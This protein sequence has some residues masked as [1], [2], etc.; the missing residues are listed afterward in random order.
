MPFGSQIKWRPPVLSSLIRWKNC[1]TVQGSESLWKDHSWS[2][3]AE[4]EASP[5]SRK[6][7][8]CGWKWYAQEACHLSITLLGLLRCWGVENFKWIKKRHDFVSYSYNAANIWARNALQKRNN[9]RWGLASLLS[10]GAWSRSWKRGMRVSIVNANT[11]V[12]ELSISHCF[13]FPAQDSQ[14]RKEKRKFS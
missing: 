11:T 7:P 14:L 1:V 9:G 4:S 2:H 5:V 8:W 10:F 3:V 6:I 12:C 13:S